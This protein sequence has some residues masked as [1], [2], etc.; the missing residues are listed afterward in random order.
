MGDS[1]GHPTRK[2]TVG[3]LGAVQVRGAAGGH[4]EVG[5][6]LLRVLLS[7]LAVAEGR[8][9]SVPALIDGLWGEEP[10]PSRERNLHSR[11]SALRRLLDEADPAGGGS[12]LVRV[13]DGYRLDLGAEGLD[14]ARFRSLAERG[15]QAAREHDD[16]AAAEFFQAALAVWPGPAME[17]AAPWCARLAA[18][19]SALEEARHDHFSRC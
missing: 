4:R 8:V 1:A 10:A 3:L 5:Q 13:A 7:L 17:D 14:V 15:R 18:E 2:L 11:V 9:V 16:L 6:Q 12:R 19:A